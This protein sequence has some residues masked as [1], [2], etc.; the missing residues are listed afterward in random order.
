MKEYY[1]YINIYYLLF[2]LYRFALYAEQGKDALMNNKYDLLYS[3]IN[4]NFDLRRKVFG[5]AVLGKENIR[6]IEIARENNCC[7][8]FCGSGGAIF[9]IIKGIE[10]DELKQKYEKEGF[11]FEII[12]P[13]YGSKTFKY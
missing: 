4:K 1:Y 13:R 2:S 5:D 3:L 12:S 10:V 11:Q 9:G 6:M 7:A 8:K